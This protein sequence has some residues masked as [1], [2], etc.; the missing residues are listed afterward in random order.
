MTDY[1]IDN[2]SKPMKIILSGDKLFIAHIYHTVSGFKYSNYNDFLG[3][4]SVN[5][6]ILDDTYHKYL[7]VKNS[8]LILD[9]LNLMYDR[10]T[11]LCQKFITEPPPPNNKHLINI[12]LISKELDI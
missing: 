8:I 3:E 10:A 1:A 12:I 11:L 9:S 2:T 6:D 4:L 5:C 7:Q